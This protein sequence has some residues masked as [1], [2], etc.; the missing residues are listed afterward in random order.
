MRR[1]WKTAVWL[2]ALLFAVLAAVAFVLYRGTQHV[3]EFYERALTPKLPPAEQ[4]KLGD[5]FERETLDL[6]NHATQV[7]RWE[8]TFTDDEINAWLANQLPQNYPR[9]LPPGVGNPRLQISPEL[10]QV[11]CRY[12]GEPL[13][14]V[15][16][17]A[18]EVHLT[19]KPNQV[20]VR[21][22]SIRAGWVPLPLKQFLDTVTDAAR[23]NGLDLT[24][25]QADGD[26]VALLQIPSRHQQYQYREIRVDTIELRDGEV[27]L[28]GHTDEAGGRE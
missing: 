6:H 11:A 2:T 21:V 28:A 14:T 8:A 22:R 15:I 27:R 26:P 18:A 25:S 4:V 23:R 5:E 12:D 10:V 16:S 1:A 19:D 17:L 3:P 24:W 9:A 7:G 20:A 13:K